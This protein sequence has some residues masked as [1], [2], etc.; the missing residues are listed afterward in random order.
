MKLTGELGDH[1]VS[2]GTFGTADAVAERKRVCTLLGLL[3]QRQQHL[4]TS[5]TE[6]LLL[7]NQDGD[8]VDAEEEEEEEEEKDLSIF[9]DTCCKLKR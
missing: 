8:G 6:R 2:L 7:A 5:V 3:D 9:V 1:H 4:V